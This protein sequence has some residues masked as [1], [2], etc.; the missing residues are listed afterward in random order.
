M[1]KTIL[2]TGASGFIGKNIKKSF[3]SEKYVLLTPSSME[4]N[5]ADD[6]SV[7]DFFRK[8][9]VDI[10]IHGAG[11]PGHRNA[12]DPTNIF[13]TNTK[14]FFNLE[15]HKQKYEKMLVL[16]SGAIYDMRNYRPKVREENFGDFIPVDEHGFCKYVCGQTIEH[17]SNIYDLRIF[18]IFGKYEDYAIRFISNAICKTLFDQPITIRQNRYFD[19]LDVDD[20]MPV[21]EWF[22]ENTPR[23]HAYNITPDNAV[24]LYDVACMVREISGKNHLAIKVAQE[25]IA[26]EYSGTNGRLRREMPDLTLTPLRK[27]IEKLYLW[28]AGNQYLIDRNLLLFDK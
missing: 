7:D 17:S 26:L 16:G 15:K 20:L 24:T 19:F 28:Y 22:T 12:K 3:L 9:K 11:K 10:V 5:V 2:L 14:M 4:L 27:S 6:V 25:G 8:N 1:T 23:H 21:L 13:L 18:G